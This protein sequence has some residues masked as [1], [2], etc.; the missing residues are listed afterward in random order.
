[1]EVDSLKRC[2]KLKIAP[3]KSPAVIFNTNKAK[4]YVVFQ[5]GGHKEVL[6]NQVK[7]PEVIMRDKTIVGCKLNAVN[8][9]NVTQMKKNWLKM[10]TQ[11][12][13]RKRKQNFDQNN[14]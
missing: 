13:S 5:T 10:N 3:E 1:M 7:Y 11:R 14:S 12:I 4:R 2:N 8:L 9:T 6:F